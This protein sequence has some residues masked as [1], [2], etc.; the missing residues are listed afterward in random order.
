MHTCCLEFAKEIATGHAR[1][2]RKVPP[3]EPKRE[4]GGPAALSDTDIESA[5]VIKGEHLDIELVV[6]LGQAE[7][8]NN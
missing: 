6:K 4:D 1:P 5:A 2:H 7:N 3:L 8:E